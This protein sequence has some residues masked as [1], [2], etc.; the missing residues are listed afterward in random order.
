MSA[1]AG[2]TG[3]ARWFLHPWLTVRMSIALGAIFIA[4]ALPK[5]VDPPSFAHMI[6][7]YRIVPGPLVNLSALLMPW[8]EIL[9]GAALCLG[10]WRRSAASIIGAML[11]VFIVAISIN[12]VRDNP[13]NC[14]CFDTKSADKTREQ[15]IDE[16]EFV[17]IRDIGML[18]M[19]AQILLATRRAAG[20]GNEGAA[21]SA[22]AN[23]P[24][25]AVVEES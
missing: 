9:A 22:A 8:V 23:E 15:L 25:P 10:L 11:V 2:G 13:V 14:G 3:F 5:L 18:V 1:P 19:V 6:Y 4:A 20:R 24:A 12:L 17:V 21:E 16:M 7:N